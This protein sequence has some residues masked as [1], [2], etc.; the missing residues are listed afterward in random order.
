MHLRHGHEHAIVA[1]VLQIEIVLR[2]AQDRLGAQSQVL[3]DA[4]HGVHDEVADFS[5]LRA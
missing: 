4:V 3:P 2:R 1:R 5:D